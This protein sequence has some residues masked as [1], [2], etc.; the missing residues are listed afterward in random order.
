MIQLIA[1]YYTSKLL[2]I[3]LHVINYN[4]LGA[5]TKLVEALA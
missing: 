1:L 3:L 5:I 4:I 2:T